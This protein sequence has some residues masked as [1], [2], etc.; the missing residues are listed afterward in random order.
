MF[1]KTLMLLILSQFLWLRRETESEKLK[2][3]K[4]FHFFEIKIQNQPDL[5]LH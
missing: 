4:N 3:L 1:T 5:A 2:H